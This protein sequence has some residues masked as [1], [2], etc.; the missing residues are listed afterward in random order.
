MHA[1]DMDFQIE[2]DFIG[3]MCPWL[4]QVSNQF[5]ERVGRVI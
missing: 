2:A 3:I 5:R 4:P 1:D